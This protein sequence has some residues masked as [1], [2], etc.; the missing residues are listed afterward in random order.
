M[1]EA[2]KDALIVQ[3]RAYLDAADSQPDGQA[4]AST[5]TSTPDLFTLLAELAALKNEVKIE[6][7]QVKNALD[8]FR[9]LFDALREAGAERAQDQERRCRQARDADNAH[10][11]DMLLQ[12]LDLHDRISAGR[13][14]AEGFSP[15]WLDRWGKAPT[16]VSSLGEGMGMNLR[17]LEEILSRR[18]VRQLTALGAPF[19]PHRMHAVEL[20]HDSTRP[21]EQVI[22]E[23][24]AGWLL[25]DELLRPAEV[26]VNRID[27]PDSQGTPR[28]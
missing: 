27:S 3:F 28:Q 1:D 16:M 8:E 17:R 23:I 6:S 21:N 10:W 18:G 4:D 11:R 22:A 15:G 12:L 20:V 14:Q 5:E 13:T 25:H 26:V 24:R 2:T 19:D 9:T 7:R